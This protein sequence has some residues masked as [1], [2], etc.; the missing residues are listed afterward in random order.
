MNP[1][2]VPVDIW[3]FNLQFVDETKNTSTDKAFEKSHLVMHAYNDFNKDLIL[4][5]L[6]IIQRVSQHLIVCFAA[7]L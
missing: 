6:S 5:L 2:D 1:K 4:T 3:I 7:I